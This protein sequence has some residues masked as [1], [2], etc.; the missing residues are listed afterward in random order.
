MKILQVAA[1]ITPENAYGGPTSVALG[2]CRAL[3]EAGHEVVLAAG[4]RGFEGDLPTTFQGV[5]VQLFPAHQV[6]PGAGFAGLM[7]PGMLRWVARKV[8]QFDAA[9]VHLA[10]DFV[11]GP[12]A[13]LAQNLGVTTVVQPHG[14]IDAS[15]KLLARPLDAALTRRVLRAATRVFHLT[16]WERDDLIEVAGPGLRLEMLRNGVSAG[17]MLA[18]EPHEGVV[19]LFLGRIH[20]RKRPLFFIEAA[21]Q[22]APEF[23]QA[24]F[25][26]V[27][28]DEG[29]GAE[30]SAAIGAAGL[31]ERLLWQGPADRDGC[32]R[33][34]AGADI[35]V[36]PSYRDTYPM[37]VLEAMA[38]GL[39]VVLA[40]DS[41]L[42][43][44]IAHA[45]AG[46]IVPSN[47]QGITDGIRALLVDARLRTEQ[48]EAAT[49]LVAEQFEMG[50]VIEKLLNAYRGEPPVS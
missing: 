7:A 45:N 14:M 3:A 27:G 20:E 39:P 50:P 11:T 36:L 18:K 22:L 21:R 41:G 6:L 34:M 15:E 43:S 16:D 23:P 2:Q 47:Q 30:A 1:V 26:M 31:G 12:A 40:D 44:A 42:A 17:S 25:V 28:P 32:R 5:Q 19:V 9:H 49:R 33:A 29:E 38:A 35:Y 48:S 4:A 37:A 46:Q 8:K 24:R 13:S 10:R